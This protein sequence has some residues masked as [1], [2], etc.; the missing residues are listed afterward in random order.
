MEQKTMKF[1]W[2]S[3]L[4]ICLSCGEDP[5]DCINSAGPV[6]TENRPLPPFS[7]LFVS[8]DIDVEWH[9]SDDA[10]RVEITCGRNLH[11]KVKSELIGR[12][13]LTI[14]NENTCNWVR[15]YNNPMKA[16]LFS[17]SPDWIK[18]EG[19]GEFTCKDTLRYSPLV[20][21]HYGAGKA[22]ILAATNEVYVDF[23]SPNDLILSGKASQ[24]HYFVQRYGK[25][26]AENMALRSLDMA[27]M[28]ENDAFIQVSGNITGRHESNRNVFLKGN[29]EISMRFLR[30][31]RILPLGQ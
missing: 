5:L 22:T 8:S 28:G 2:L 4:L 12:D 13:T 29:P 27:M 18:L 1:L 30:K 24:A 26:K 10:P 3:L 31:G 25:L 21:Q 20:I 23:L 16:V 14:A 15:S 9:Y 19:Y 6:R 17:R 11:R 7:R